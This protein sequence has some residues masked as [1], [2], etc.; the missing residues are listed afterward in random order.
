MP[1]D[2]ESG[3]AL[4]VGG[5]SQILDHL[6]CGLDILLNCKVREVHYDSPSPMIVTDKENF[7]ANHI[8]VAVP[9]GVLKHNQITFYPPLSSHI[10]RSIC[11]LDAGLMDVVILRFAERFWPSDVFVFGVPPMS[12]VSATAD[13]SYSSHKGL[14]D[15]IRDR[16]QRET[17]GS[18]CD[19]GDSDEES[20][21]EFPSSCL[22]SSFM[23]LTMSRPDNCP[24]LLGQVY[25]RRAIQLE[26]MSNEDVAS[27]ALECLRIIFGDDA[28]APVGCVFHKWGSDDLAYGSW[29]SVA[30]GVNSRDLFNFKLPIECHGS[31][32]LQFAGEWTE[33][34]QMGL[35][36]GAYASGERAADHIIKHTNMQHLGVVVNQSG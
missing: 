12:N 7:T 14:S 4:V 21:F 19:S 17:G 9:N 27:A 6:S 2:A 11:A 1:F 31:C 15:V 35:L 34:M 3:E 18:A 16:I 36:Q 8:I 24:L 5:V 22:F 30:V 23:N 28:S 10:Q 26:R 13:M 29:N 25:G 32:S 20:G 33:P